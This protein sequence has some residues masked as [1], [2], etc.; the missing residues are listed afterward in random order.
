MNYKKIL[1]S[2]WTA[3]FPKGKEKHFSVVK[4]KRDNDDPQVIKSV[5]LEAVMSKRTFKIEP[6]ELNDIEVWLEGW[7]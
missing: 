1:N 2:K 4:V 3:A 5:T 7:K 6:H